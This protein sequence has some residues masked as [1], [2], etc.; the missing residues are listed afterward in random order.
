[1]LT[2]ENLKSNTTS[3]LNFIEHKWDHLTGNAREGHQDKLASWKAL[4]ETSV[5]GHLDDVDPDNPYILFLPNDFIFPGG[6]FVVQ[7]YWDSYFI[8]LS[9]LR[10]NR[11]ELAKGM[12]DNCLFLVEQ[13]GMVIANRKRWA[14]GSQLPFLSEMVYEVYQ[15][16]KDKNWLGKALPILEMEYRYYWLDQDHLAHQGLSRY[17]APSCFPRNYIASIT[18]DNEATWDLCP[19]FDVED[20]LHLLPVDLNSNLFVYERNFAYFY[21]QLGQEALASAWEESAQKRANT[22]NELMWDEQDGLYYDYNYRDNER[23]KVKSLVTYFPLFYGLANTTQARRVASNISLFEKEFGLV[24]CDQDYGYSDRQW[25]YPIGWAPL[26]WIAYKAL[27]NYGYGEV[28][29]RIA[30]QWINLNYDIW[31]RTGKLFEKYDVVQGS[32]EVLTDRYKNQEGFGW[33][34]AIFHTLV[35]D[36]IA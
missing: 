6:R 19:R 8:I 25:N 35:L 15:I 13:H 11:F 9:L 1:M 27:K 31:G 33:T 30:L 3:I 17:H 28:A 23:K 26:H 34:N 7:F 14:A 2:L 12:V 4:A 36:L 32:H 18:L 16:N 22:I 21:K 29:E 5:D 20:V 24:T 10:G